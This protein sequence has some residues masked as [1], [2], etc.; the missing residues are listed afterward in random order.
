[1]CIYI[2]ISNTY[3]KKLRNDYENANYN[4]I[5]LFLQIKMISKMHL[6]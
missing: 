6:H 2:Y 3:T 5:L 1:M 4:V